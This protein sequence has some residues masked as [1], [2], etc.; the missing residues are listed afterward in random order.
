M[1]VQRCELIVTPGAI[2]CD[3]SQ[4]PDGERHKPVSLTV[5][6]TRWTDCPG[7]RA[8]YWAS[9]AEPDYERTTPA[10]EFG[11][12]EFLEIEPIHTCNLRCVMCHVTYQEVSKRRLDPRFVEKIF[13]MEGKWALI[14]SEYEPM[15]HPK[16]AEIL[17]GLSDRG[18][19]LDLTTNGTLFTDRVIDLIADC[20][21]RRVTISFDGI[22][23]ATF[24]A[25]RQRA[26][27][28]LALKRILSFKERVQQHNPDCSFT[29]NYTVL[30]DNIAE[31]ADA[32]TF[33]ELNGFDHIGFI[34]MV[35]RAPTDYLRSQSIE[36]HL[37]RFQAQIDE[38]AR[39]IIDGN[40]HLSMTN[41]IGIRP[42]FADA[43]PSHL[44]ASLVMSRNANARVPRNPRGYYQ[45]RPFPGVPVNCASPYKG[46]KLLYD[47]SLQLCSKFTIG[48]IDD[49]GSLLELWRGFNARRVRS[50]ITRQ[51]KICHTCDY[52]RFC[53]RA[54]S[55]DHTKSDSFVTGSVEPREIAE[56]LGHS[57]VEWGGEYYL[58]KAGI[59]A[60]DPRFDD[61]EPHVLF[62]C[63]D[64]ADTLRSVER[65][66][67]KNGPLEIKLDHKRYR[68]WRLGTW[69]MAASPEA[70]DGETLRIE[71]F[72]DLYFATDL[73]ELLALIGNPG[74]PTSAPAPRPS[75]P[76]LVD[77]VDG[78]NIVRYANRYL[79][80]PQAAGPLDVDKA[81]LA[82]I[83]GLFDAATLA[84]LRSQIAALLNEPCSGAD[85]ARS[86]A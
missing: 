24:E 81:D 83:P 85:R 29:I 18:M 46:L 73:S 76:V 54:G 10:D 57:L 40:Y 49:P 80:I 15:A 48:N 65:F 33:W 21:F 7:C 52:F 77:S 38:A 86:S 37:D 9:T 11:P 43:I 28:E 82:A 35:V 32:V 51:P 64:F 55:I 19:K 13:G 67:A 34:P 6:A 70:Y 75:E 60:F 84:E 53:I 16:I 41:T 71:T 50:G 31:M 5:T 2:S 45:N 79:G 23:K 56:I 1:A 63:A 17:R 61:V 36:A 68:F 39:R 4:V 69:L 66:L 30:N 12:P 20:R 3:G 78:Y 26:N 8:R 59:G 42:S 72:H 62:H 74:D 58:L 47:G 25:I 14:G 27:Y 22:T 44:V